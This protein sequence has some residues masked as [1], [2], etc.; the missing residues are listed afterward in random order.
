MKIL[1]KYA[2]NIYS[3]LSSPKVGLCV[4]QTLAMKILIKSL[5]TNKEND[6]ISEATQVQSI[7]AKLNVFL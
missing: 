7:F 5:K 2:F 3:I 4:K 6:G 1:A